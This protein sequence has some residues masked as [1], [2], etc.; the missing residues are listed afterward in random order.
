[1]PPKRQNRLRVAETGRVELVE[2][3]NVDKPDNQVETGA[4]TKTR[5]ARQV[6]F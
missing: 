2:V 1:M 4:K 5:A 3:E 6:R